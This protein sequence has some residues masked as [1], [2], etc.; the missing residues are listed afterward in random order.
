MLST[1]I[2]VFHKYFNVII[3]LYTKN[4]F[5]TAFGYHGNIHSLTLSIPLHLNDMN[6]N[7]TS[8]LQTCKKIQYQHVTLP[9]NIPKKGKN[10][11]Y[12]S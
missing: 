8:I 1:F 10:G 7:M 5:K 2:T 3:S 11:F 9:Q 12:N 6:H 4:H